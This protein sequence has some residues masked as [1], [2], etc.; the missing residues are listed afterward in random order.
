MLVVE[1]L[2]HVE[3]LC[4]IELMQGRH[5][6]YLVRAGT[7]WWNLMQFVG[8]LWHLA[9]FETWF[10]LKCKEKSKRTTNNLE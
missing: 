3:S 6:G 9:K 7:I 4:I 10:S 5:F 8:R 1:G 2:C